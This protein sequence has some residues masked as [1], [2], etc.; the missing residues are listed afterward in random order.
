MSAAKK[1]N[2]SAVRDFLRAGKVKATTRNRVSEL[3]FVCVLFRW[4]LFVIATT[5]TRAFFCWHLWYFHLVW[6]D[7]KLYCT[8]LH[9]TVLDSRQIGGM[10][11]R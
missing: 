8:V 10:K 7:E 5:V 9:C 1:G 4:V 3:S 2:V 11:N 6:C